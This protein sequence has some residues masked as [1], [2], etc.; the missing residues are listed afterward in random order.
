VSQYNKAKGSKWEA[1]IENYA[2]ENGVKARRLPRAGAKDIG[3]V[4]IELVNGHVVVVEAKNTKTHDMAQYLREAEVE[5]G[6]YE[7]KYSKLAYGVVLTK[8]RQKGTGDGRVTMTFEVFLNL[9]KW[10][11]LA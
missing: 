6:H 9:L 5:A 4:A 1:D 11:S 7:D 10:E 3:D 8:T 2:N